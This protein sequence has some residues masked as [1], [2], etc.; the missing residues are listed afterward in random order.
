[1]TNRRGL[2][3]VE[4]LIAM[5]VAGIIGA[6]LVALLMSQGRWSE[7]VTAERDSRTAARGPVA[8]LSAELRMV[9]GFWGVEAASNNAVTLRIPYALGV[10]CG[11]SGS[12]YIVQLLP[13][14]AALAAEPGHSGYAMRIN[15]GAYVWYGV[16]T[17]AAS[18]LTSACTGATPAVE[19]LPG[20]TLVALAKP[21]S[22]P[23]TV[24]PGTPVMLARRIRYSYANSATTGLRML[25]REVLDAG[26]GQ[27]VAEEIGGPFTEASVARFTFFTRAAP[28]V[29]TATVPSPLTTMAGIQVGLPGR[30]ERNARMATGTISSNLSTAF[31]FTNRV[32]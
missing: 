25:Y 27:V 31:Y 23:A 6:S 2:S 16:Q 32:H 3:L 1:M 17:K 21:A 12:D 30:A 9:D 29:A 19:L 4:L 14:D 22:P 18:N 7:R 5:V 11:Q 20:A 8:V 10:Y 13:T 15:G 24:D 28:T 26:G